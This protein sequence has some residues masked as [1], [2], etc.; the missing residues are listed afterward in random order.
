MQEQARKRGITPAGGDKDGNGNGNE[1][2]GGKAAGNPPRPGLFEEVRRRLRVKHYSLRTERAYLGWI[3]RFVAENG[4][5][6]PRT[7][8]GP[9]VEAFLSRLAVEGR[10]AANT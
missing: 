5:R 2:A 8:G 6:H 1:V 9:E 7:L 4:R 3:R 10:V